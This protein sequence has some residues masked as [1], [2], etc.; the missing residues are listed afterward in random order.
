MMNLI[1]SHTHGADGRRRRCHPKRFG[2]GATTSIT[3]A[4]LL[5]EDLALDSL[6]LV[7]V[8]LIF[9]ITSGGN[10]PGRDSQPALGRRPR[11]QLEEPT[12][13]RRLTLCAPTLRYGRR[14]TASPRHD[15]TS[16][17]RDYSV[18]LSE[19]LV[20]SSGRFPARIPCIPT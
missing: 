12:S 19:Q 17:C 16:G 1:G 15:I 3:P 2:K 9:K 20:Y 6:D 7:A 4:S 10:R 13:S 18:T 14:P 11:D 5:L 8:I